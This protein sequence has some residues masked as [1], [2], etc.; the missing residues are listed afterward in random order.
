MGRMTWFDVDGMKRGEWTVEEDRKLVAY[1]EENGLDNWGLLAKRAGLQRCGK[2]CR[3]R[4]LNYLRPGI[5]RSKFSPQEEQEIIKFHALL[6]NRWSVIAKQIPNRTDHDIKNHWN[7]CLKKRLAKGRTDPMMTPEPALVT[8]DE[9]T[10]TS[11]RSPS[12]APSTTFSSTGFARLLN[13]LAAGIASRKYRLDKIKM[14]ILTEQP[15]EA[16]AKENMLITMEEEDLITCFMDI[17]EKLSTASFCE[18]PCCEDSTYCYATSDW[19][20]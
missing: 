10:S 4:W 18:L 1:I 3:L 9:A 19:L 17:D 6:G 7:S 16:S 2:S 8:V 15:R 20:N 14:L 13:K 11:T 12:P 5:K